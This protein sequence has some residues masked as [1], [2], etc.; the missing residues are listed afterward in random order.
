[1]YISQSINLSGAAALGVVGYTLGIG[2]VGVVGAIIV[3]NYNSNLI[4]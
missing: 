4:Y 1:M 3:F 2:V